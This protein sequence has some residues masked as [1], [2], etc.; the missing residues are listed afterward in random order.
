MHNEN[1]FETESA[2][3]CS[4]KNVESENV[5]NVIMNEFFKF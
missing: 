1:S 3:H 5:F 4:W 2:F